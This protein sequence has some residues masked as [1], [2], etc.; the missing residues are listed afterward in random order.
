MN[1]WLSGLRAVACTVRPVFDLARWC[2][3][4]WILSDKP[5]TYDPKLKRQILDSAIRIY[6]RA[7]AM[8]LMLI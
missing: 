2:T 3:D 1:E 6:E 8:H 5:G 7:S 4:H